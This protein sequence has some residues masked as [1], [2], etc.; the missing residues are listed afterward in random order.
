MNI[1]K[2]GHC[3][4]VI[5]EKGRTILTDPGAWTKEQDTLTGIDIV[6]I[7]HEHA[8]H[9][10][11]ESVKQIVANNPEAVIVTNSAVASLLEKEQITATVI[12]G[13]QTKTVKDIMITGFGKDHAVI[14]PKVSIIMN[15]GYLIEQKV[16]LPGDAFTKPG[17]PVEILAMPMIGPWMK[18]A[19]SIDW[20][21]AIKP[22]ICIPVHDG[23]LNPRQWI[24]GAPT[25]ILGEAGIIFDPVE[26]GEEK[27]LLIN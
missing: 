17:V 3:C 14:H 12:E 6:L 26:P 22:K 20:A 15:T 21:L 5:K 1:R 4:L 25:K 2:I 7:T 18:I 9:F 11:V 8:D 13:G 16:F 27:E 19:E 23:M 24:Y 10:H